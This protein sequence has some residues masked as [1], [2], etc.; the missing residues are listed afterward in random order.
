[1]L[2]APHDVVSPGQMPYQQG[3]SHSVLVI[4][5]D[6]GRVM[7]DR[8]IRIPD[9]IPMKRIMPA[10]VKTIRFMVFPL[11]YPLIRAGE[12]LREY[13]NENT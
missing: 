7:L 6:S 2:V 9:R 13:L 8:T 4:T 1:M 10:T 12:L 5:V 11:G 3:G